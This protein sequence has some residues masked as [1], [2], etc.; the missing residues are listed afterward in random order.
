[1]LL[2]WNNAVS[3]SLYFCKDSILKTTCKTSAL[4]YPLQ[5][6]K[7]KKICKILSISFELVFKKIK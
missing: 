7:V 2:L 3:I 5:K 6:T 1:M 4:K